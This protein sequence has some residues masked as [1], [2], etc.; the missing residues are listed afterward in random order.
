MSFELGLTPKEYETCVLYYGQG[1]S[2]TDVAAI[3][4]CGPRKVRYRLAAARAKFPNLTRRY[5]RATSN[6]FSDDAP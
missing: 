4:K 1:L 3:Q 2:V 5:H 6:L